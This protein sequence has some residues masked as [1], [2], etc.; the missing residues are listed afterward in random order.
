M[1]YYKLE[2]A[3]D[4]EFYELVINQK[5]YKRIIDDINDSSKMFL[6]FV[7]EDDVNYIFNKNNINS[8]VLS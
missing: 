4:T 7:D 2:I 8:I 6:D 3:I 1:N 5:S